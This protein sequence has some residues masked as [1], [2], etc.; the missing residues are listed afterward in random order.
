MQESTFSTTMSKWSNEDPLLVSGAGNAV[1][2]N[3]GI[4]QDLQMILEMDPSIVDHSPAPMSFAND[5]STQ[6]LHSPRYS[7]P[8]GW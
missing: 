5:E 3:V 7:Q 1:R 4:D 8:Q 6:T 2:V